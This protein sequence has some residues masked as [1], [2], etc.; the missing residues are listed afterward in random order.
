MTMQ[1][2][3]IDSYDETKRMLNTMRKFNSSSS[4]SIKEQLER[5]TYQTPPQQQPQ[6]RQ[7][8]GGKENKDLAVINNVEVVMNSSD[9]SDLTLQEDQKGKISQL[10]D[11]FRSEVSEL[12]DFGKL[13]FYSGSAKLDGTITDMKLG[14][15]L[16]AGDDEG[17]FLTNMSMLKIS[18]DV[19]DIINKLKAFEPKFITTI[20]GIILYQKEN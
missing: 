6:Q 10:I 1:K 19:M 8:M 14:F 9:P 18:D 2:K 11:D 13:S 5:P 16:S 12:A 20:N 15:L 17:L 3:P 4:S 7:E